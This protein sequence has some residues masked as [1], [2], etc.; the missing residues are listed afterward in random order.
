MRLRRV[1]IL[2]ALCLPCASLYAQSNYPARP[3]RII[4]PFAPGGS[5]DTLSRLLG[6]ELTKSL[7]QPVI[8]DNRPGGASMI[9]IDA[10]AKSAPDGY[11]IGL[12]ATGALAINPSLFAKMPFDPQKD[13]APIAQL[14]T[15][16]I[17]LVANAASGITTLAELTTRSKA[18]PESFAFGTTGN[19]SSMHLAGELLKL[20]TGIVMTHVPYKGSAPAVADAV[21]GQ[22]PLAF[23]DLTS[24]LPHIRA[25]KVRS[26]GTGGIDRTLTAPELATLAE[27]GVPGFDAK[28]WFGVVGP[29]GTPATIVERLNGE[30]N[31]V[32]NTPE[33]RDKAIAV[34]CEPATSTPE[35]F[36]GLIRREIAKYAQAVKTAKLKVE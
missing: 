1:L 22:I 34:G 2:L 23:V 15:I 21:A 19:G 3:I 7:G 32:L 27:N 18:K 20:Q 8:V 16:P 31:R 29:A 14:A 35:Q 6:Q 11:T 5:A 12:G 10:V 9:G 4:V 28:G 30:I 26:L 33:I 17:V 13:L 24:A 25:G 36:A